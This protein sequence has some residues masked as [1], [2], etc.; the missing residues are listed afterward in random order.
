M[1]VFQN[2][3]SKAKIVQRHYLNHGFSTNNKDYRHSLLEYD[4]VQCGRDLE[5]FW[6]NL[7]SASPSL[8]MAA[9]VHYRKSMNFTA[10]RIPH[11]TEL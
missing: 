11:P 1:I 2:K 3:T 7:L 8:N 4:T 5:T 10:Y 9:A 6:I